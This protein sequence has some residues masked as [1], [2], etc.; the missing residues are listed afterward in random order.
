MSSVIITRLPDLTTF[1]FDLVEEENYDE[2]VKVTE[3][4]VET[5]SSPSDHAAEEPIKIA[6][7]LMVTETPLIGQQPVGAVGSLRVF[8]ATKFLQECKKKALNV[9]TTQDG[10]FTNLMIESFSYSKNIAKNRIFDVKFKQVR[11][12]VAQTVQ[13]PP[14]A[15]AKAAKTGASTAQNAGQQAT[16]A[17]STASSATDQSSLY[18]VLSSIGVL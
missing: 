6:M 13:I 10:T 2:S 9:T 14:T 12:G 11:F 16:S 15:P 5:G 8:L 7:R 1:E 3:H 18:S 17:T 4:P